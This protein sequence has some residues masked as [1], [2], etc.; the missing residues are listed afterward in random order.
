MLLPDG[1]VLTCAHVVFDRSLPEPDLQ[2]DFVGLPGTPSTPAAVADGQWVPPLSDERGDVALVKLAD[3]PPAASVARLRGLTVGWDRPVHACGFPAQLEGGVWVQ[4]ALGGPSGPGSEWIQLNN[5]RPNG[6]FGRRGFSG[7]AVIDNETGDVLGMVVANLTSGAESLGWMIP[8]ETI[9]RYLPRV[10]ALV[11]TPQPAVNSAWPPV[12]SLGR[13]SSA[14]TDLPDPLDVLLDDPLVPER[15]RFCENCNSPVGRSTDRGPGRVEGFCQYC[16]A[17]YYFRPQLA[18]G[19][20][21]ENRYEIA[22]CLARGGRG[23]LYLARDNNLSGRYV[24]LKGL[25]YSDADDPH[26]FTERRLLAE[27]E[28]PNIVRVFNFVS[29]TSARSAARNTYLVMEYVGGLSLREVIRNARRSRALSVEAVVAYGLGILDALDYL[30]SKDLLYCDMKPDNVIHS[31]HGVKL[32]DLG[33]VRRIGDEAPIVAT[34]GYQVRH[35]EIDEHGLTVRSDLFSVGVTL[36]ELARASVDWFNRP[37]TQ[38]ETGGVELGIES[39]RRVI[40]RA[41]ADFEHRFTSAAEM[42]DQLEGV[43]REVFAL[44]EGASHRTGS[45]LFGAVGALLDTG[46]GE[47]VP[48]ERWAS[49][50]G[51]A[52]LEGRLFPRDAAAALP[53]PLRHDEAWT[54]T[55]RRGVAAL[56]ND[57]LPDA[58]E[59]FDEVYSALPGEMAPK[60][61]LGLCAERLGMN[62]RAEWFYEAV[63]RRDHTQVSGAFGLAR[64]R[65]S[66]GDRLGAAAVLDEVPTAL[67]RPELPAIAAIRALTAP[68]PADVAPPGTQEFSMAMRRL[69]GIGSPSRQLLSLEVARGLLDWLL[70]DPTRDGTLVGDPVL[71]GL[72]SEVTARGWLERTLRELAGQPLGTRTRHGL[73][74]F[75]DQISSESRL[76]ID[77]GKAIT[78]T[79]LPQFELTVEQNEYLSVTDTRMDAVLSVGLRRAAGG[80]ADADARMRVTTKPGSRLSFL[81]EVFPRVTNVGET[82]VRI[83]EHTMEFSLGTWDGIQTRDYH[84]SF[85]VEP[86]G[87]PAAEARELARVELVSAGREVVSVKPATIVARLVEDAALSTRIDARV[88]HYSAR[89][90]LRDAVESSWAFYDAGDLSEANSAL[91]R[92]VRLASEL[93]DVETLR[94]LE[95]I[96]DIH[97]PDDGLVTIK[98]SLLARD[99]PRFSTAGSRVL[100]TRT[101]RSSQVV[102]SSRYS[103]RWRSRRSSRFVIG[104]LGRSNRRTA[105]FS[106]I[107]PNCGRIVPH[108]APYCEVCGGRLTE[109][110]SSPRR[111]RV[112]CVTDELAEVGK[113]LR[114]AF[115]IAVADTPDPADDPEPLSH[116]VRLR[117]LLESRQADV[118]PMTRVVELTVDRTTEPVDFTVVPARSG[119]IPLVFRIYLDRDG[120]LLQEIQTELDVIETAREVAG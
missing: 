22:G 18:P 116:P 40:K 4:A 41:T 56:A 47:V 66:R 68:L 104:G 15:N 37:R 45:Q 2:V 39:L 105:G 9:A 94:R 53:S 50:R 25:I 118:T 11:D 19:D 12:S 65:L 71:P 73:L 44:R 112:W 76:T 93:G 72:V 35:E 42:R 3:V 51:A 84:L 61:A 90:N 34:T 85:A 62:A 115:A 88:A 89:D 49:S 30:H 16:R 101:R 32:I 59:C 54:A 14:V 64:M 70:V 82:G 57:D 28:H 33:S 110:F 60:L 111:A 107:C 8:V 58:E 86:G 6:V 7:A 81:K 27:L 26:A 98:A 119:S 29:H 117:V 20:V 96:V 95:R 106:P 103:S 10:A 97:D 108:T 21:V 78:P 99:F 52:R 75:A 102:T 92:A 79:R 23:W 55:W 17:P 43:L 13:W 83:D 80:D 109:V 87:S 74:E 67:V 36:D 24:V 46:L 63:W 77:V 100:S 120:Q 69:P 114:I 1:Y 91:S 31:R 113:A 38:P 48:L 5:V